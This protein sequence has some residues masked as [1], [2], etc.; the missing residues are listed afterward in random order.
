[1]D[2]TLKERKDLS[3]Q[4][5]QAEKTKQAKLEEFKKKE[6]LLNDFPKILASLEDAT[7]PI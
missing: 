7:L 1:M 6:Q 3:V 5:E 2:Q 4:L